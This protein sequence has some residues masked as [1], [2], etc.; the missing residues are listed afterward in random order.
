MKRDPL[1]LQSTIRIV[2]A[3][4][5]SVSAYADIPT[6]ILGGETLGNAAYA[7]LVSSDGSLS[8][9]NLDLSSNSFIT[10][11]SMNG[12]GNSLIGGQ[13]SDALAYAAFVSSSGG[14]T[15]LSFSMSS[16]S[17]ID[18]VSINNQGQGLMGGD[19]GGAY[20]AFITASGTVNPYMI[21]ASSIRSVSLNDDGVGLVGGE[22]SS[23]FLYAAFVDSEETVTD[24]GSLPTDGSSGINS[25]S[26]N[27]QGQGLIGGF[28]SFSNY[29]AFVTTDSHAIANTI[30]FPVP[31]F[32][33]TSQINSVAINSDGLGLIGGTVVDM[34]NSSY[35]AYV[36]YGDDIVTHVLLDGTAGGTIQSVAINSSG[37]GLLGGNNGSDLYAALVQPDGSLAEL[38]TDSTPGFINSVAINDAGVGLLGGQIHDSDGWA[39]LM[40]PNG[41]LTLLDMSEIESIN[42]VSLPLTSQATPQCI[43][44]FTTPLTTQ[45]AAAAALETRFISQNRLWT[46]GRHTHVA[47][48]DLLDEEMLVAANGKN[49]VTG[50]KSMSH[51]RAFSCK[52][53]SIWLSPFG[54]YAHIKEEGSFPTITNTLGGALLGYDYQAPN[55]MLGAALGYAFNYVHLKEDLGHSKV[56][57]ELLSFY[58]SYNSDHF[59]FGGVIWGGVYQ[60]WNERHTLS[61][62]T[63]EAETRGWILSPHVEMAFPYAMDCEENYFVEPFFML[64]WVNSWQNEFT[65]TGAAGFNLEMDDFYGSLLQSEVGLRFYER[66][67]Y[68][69]GDFCLE[70]KL[71]YVNQA[72]FNFNSVTTSFAGSASTFPIAIGSSKVENLGSVQLLGSFVPA[73]TS[74]PYGGFSL[75]AMANGSYQSYFAN[76]FIGADF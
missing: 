69:W 23:N 18:T 17:S 2:L 68:N 37:V 6:G 3:S 48:H 26:I 1:S 15:P 66:F 46:R 55:Y 67:G 71:S 72:P 63:S 43:G 42:S 62:I 4:M 40:A 5:A 53:S 28:L 52:P 45:L 25:V 14:V 35:A 10:S 11:V 59:W 20:A 51:D 64:D 22:G 30:N 8:S 24:V 9:P 38:N 13:D 60:F 41:T 36:T 56:Q 32:E 58:A 54:N 34:T 21:S 31:G 74:Y 47:T 73:N 27:N 70:E 39:A 33:V 12:L 75:Q 50:S 76:L 65:E 19:N 44:P 57:E 7:A 16:D 29:A 49:P 61:I